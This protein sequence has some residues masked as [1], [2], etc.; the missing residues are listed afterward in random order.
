MRLRAASAARTLPR[1]SLR[2]ETVY[3]RLADPEHDR[4]VLEKAMIDGE[5]ATVADAVRALVGLSPML[6]SRGR[7]R[8]EVKKNRD[9]EKEL[10]RR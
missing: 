2:Y 9:P 1:M 7:P 5:H 8:K 3:V 10:A 4:A 6:K